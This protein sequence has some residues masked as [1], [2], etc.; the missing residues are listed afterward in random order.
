MEWKSIDNIPKD[1]SDIIIK[2]HIGVVSAWYH[3][4]NAEW[5]CYDDMFSLDGYD[6]TI[7]GWLPFNIED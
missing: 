7:E 6:A 4:E 1:G 2:T 5:V 3:I